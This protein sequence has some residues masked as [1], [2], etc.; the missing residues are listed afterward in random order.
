MDEKQDQLEDDRIKEGVIN[1]IASMISG[2]NDS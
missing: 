2:E 1:K